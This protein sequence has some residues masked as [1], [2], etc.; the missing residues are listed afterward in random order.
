[1][2]KSGSWIASE[3]AWAIKDKTEIDGGTA[4]MGIEEKVLISTET[5]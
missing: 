3:P 2:R 5:F 1:M 4:F